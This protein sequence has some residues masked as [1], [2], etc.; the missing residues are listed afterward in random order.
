[1]S[2]WQLDGQASPCA[3]VST[4]RGRQGRAIRCID[5]SAQRPRPRS[6]PTRE[7]SERNRLQVAQSTG[8]EADHR[9]FFSD[10]RLRSRFLRAGPKFSLN[11]LG[12]NGTL[13]GWLPHHRRKTQHAEFIH[14]VNFWVIMELYAQASKSFDNACGSPQAIDPPG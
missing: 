10:A 2:Q 1:M 13:V 8:G 9:A 6:V 5:S 3:F 12:R 7:A 4:S 11:G 14:W